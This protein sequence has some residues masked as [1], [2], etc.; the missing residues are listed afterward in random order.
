MNRL[1]TWRGRKEPRIRLAGGLILLSV[2]LWGIALWQGE[3]IKSYA[4]DIQIR[5]HGQGV[6]AQ[7]VDRMREAVGMPEGERQQGERLPEMAAWSVEYYVEAENPSLGFKQNVTCITVSGSMD[8]V[9]KDRLVAGNYG[10]ADDGEGCVISS[11]TAWTLFGTMN[12]TGRSISVQ[13]REFLVRGVTA[14]SYPLVILPAKRMGTEYFACISF[15]SSG[16]DGLEGLAEEMAVR[17]GLPE[18]GTRINGSF[19]CAAVRLGGTLPGWA[20]L[21]CF[22]RRCKRMER[23]ADRRGPKWSEGVFKIRRLLLFLL[24]LGGA[25]WLIWYGFRFPGEFIPSR[26]SDFSFYSEKFRQI[27]E[28]MADIAVLPK[29]RWDIEMTGA[30]E[31]AMVCQ[32]W[33]ALLIM[34]TGSLIILPSAAENSDFPCEPAP[35]E[36]EAG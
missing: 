23:T 29:T 13:G 26:W 27:K 36:E 10:Y 3:R 32:A 33:A 22:C 12:V 19:Y 25:V 7:T 18:H 28:N 9:V 1:R 5:Y 21:F 34:I 2:L 6:P 24:L 20:L 35:S 16:S 30:F 17:F 11:K 14:A 31:A 15:S 8:L 4:G